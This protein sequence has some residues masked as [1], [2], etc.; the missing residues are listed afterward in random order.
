M[1]EY[2]GKLYIYN[3]YPADWETYIDLPTGNNAE[4]N[5]YYVYPGGVTEAPKN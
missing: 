4:N 3:H 1:L 5:W 2:E